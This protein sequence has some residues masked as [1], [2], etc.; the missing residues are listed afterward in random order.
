M[1]LSGYGADPPP[2]CVAPDGGIRSPPLDRRGRQI[3]V[4]GERDRVPMHA[5]PQGFHAEV[6]PDLRPRREV[7]ARRLRTPAGA[8]H[9]LY[10][11]VRPTSACA[12]ARDVAQIAGNCRSTPQGER[13]ATRHAPRPSWRPPCRQRAYGISERLRRAGGARPSRKR[14][15]ENV[16]DSGHPLWHTS[17]PGWSRRGLRVVLSRAI[18]NERI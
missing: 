3:D 12:S 10:V 6:G 7:G 14:T 4:R 15:G 18:G 1:W 17:C 2:Q 8:G 16:H 5:H 9:I 11:H 13:R